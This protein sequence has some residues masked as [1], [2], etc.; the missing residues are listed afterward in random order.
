MIVGAVG[1]PPSLS[2]LPRMDSRFRGNDVWVGAAKLAA[3]ALGI[4]FRAS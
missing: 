1:E 4:T 3:R 2:L